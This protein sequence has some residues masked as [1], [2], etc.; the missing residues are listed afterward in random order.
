MKKKINYS[1]LCSIIKKANY[2]NFNY[3]ISLNNNKINILKVELL[4]YKIIDYSYNNINI[5]NCL[6]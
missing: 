2:N 5:N 3:S 6:I 1:E 4:I